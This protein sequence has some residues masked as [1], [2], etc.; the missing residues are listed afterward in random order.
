MTWNASDLL[1]STGA[2]MPDSYYEQGQNEW[3]QL[4]VDVGDTEAHWRDQL[5]RHITLEVY[6]YSG[7]DQYWIDVFIE[8]LGSMRFK[9]LWEFETYM[10]RMFPGTEI[11]TP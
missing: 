1:A 8:G 3:A 5:Q 4:Q 7:L 6:D 9:S 10:E 11:L 2:A